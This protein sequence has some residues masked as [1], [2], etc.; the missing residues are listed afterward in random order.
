MSKLKRDDVRAALRADDVTAHVQIKGQW[1]GHW[2]RAR[3]CAETD[4]ESLAFAISEDGMWHC[5]S[6]DKGGDLFDLL[7]LFEGLSIKDDF[8]KVLELAASLAG[9]DTN[10]D[11]DMFGLGPTK[12]A[13]RPRPEARPLAPLPERI[14]KA[15]QRARWVWDRLYKH[16]EMALAAAYLKTRKLD[17]DAVLAR[18]E[19]RATPLRITQELRQQIDGRAPNVTDELR[20][21]WWT[22]GTRKSTLSMVVPVRHV[23]TGAMVD[24]RARRVEPATD[25]P[26]IIG[27]VGGVTEAPAERG[28]TRQLIGCYGNPHAVDADHVVIVEGALD[29]LTALQLWP[30]AAVLGAVNAGTLGLVTG[31]AASIL[32]ARD[33]TSRLTIV[34]QADPPRT[35]KDGRVVPGAADAAINEDPN[36]ATK[37]AVCLLSPNRVGW[38]FCGLSDAVVDGKPVK[39][40]NDLVRAGINVH[41]LH[42]WWNETDAST[43]A[44]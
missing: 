34:E 2:M 12:P 24:L 31:F 18:E 11:A 44:V 20:T 19:L 21:L 10:P 1:R 23:M 28:K 33:S 36:S 27:M 35:L 29:Y 3:R 13:P 5:H 43:G 6:C 25:Q 30:D 16:E 15:V 39:D 32:A 41:D 26:K 17:P 22:M 4:H 9:I 40:L 37:R 42:R 7:A 38:V 14:A 8:G